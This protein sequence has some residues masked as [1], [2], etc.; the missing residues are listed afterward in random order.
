MIE[1]RQNFSCK[2][3]RNRKSLCPRSRWRNHFVFPSLLNSPQLHITFSRMGTVA[4]IKAAIDRLSPQERCELEALLHPQ[5][6][7]DWDRQMAADA[8]PGG[9][10]YQ[11]KEDSKS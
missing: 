9:K 6:D 4:E 11:L 10:L 7:D 3:A 5:V 8:E 2:T 1:T